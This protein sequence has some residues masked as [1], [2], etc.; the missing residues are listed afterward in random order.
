MFLPHNG[1]HG[2]VG[3]D[4]QT[5]A[6]IDRYRQLFDE[7]TAAQLVVDDRDGRI[8]EANRAAADFYGVPASRLVGTTLDDHG[9]DDPAALRDALDVG[10]DI[11][12]H[13][14][15]LPQ[16]HASGDVRLTEIYGTPIGAGSPRLV[17][18]IVHD[19][20][21]R[22]RA[23]DREREFLSQLARQDAKQREATMT[24]MGELVAGV[25]H[26]VRN[27][28]FAL[29]SAIDSL[30][31][32]LADNADFSRYAPLITTQVDRLSALMADLLDYGRPAALA[33]RDARVSEVVAT[34]IEFTAPVAER[35][36]VRLA[37]AIEC[38]VERR[39]RVDRFRLAQ[40]LQNLLANAVQYAPKDSVVHL[41][42][43]DASHGA[44]EFTVIDEG[45]G[46][47]P[48][49]LAHVFEPFHSKRPGGTGL[50]LALVHRTVHDHN[51]TV[52]AENR[53]SPDGV[54]IGALVRV[55]IPP[56]PPADQ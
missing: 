23:R 56:L 22:E 33:L 41:R 11:G 31:Q 42:A 14:V 48:D 20:T 25:A 54:V 16:R 49:A 29:S 30:R 3:E 10:A 27:P 18:L 12:V 15:G 40:A 45:P 43:R 47:D 28:L 21:D 7:S 38:E 44:V 2:N 35:A 4:A 1:G 32:R 36:H 17:H 53:M 46:F 39:L 6:A 13:L 8:V 26:E 24:R 51:G 50:G 9:A 19:I 34:A 52:A 37:H 5:S 55:V